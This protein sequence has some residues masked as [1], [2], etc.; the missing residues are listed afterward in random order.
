MEAIMRMTSSYLGGHFGGPLPARATVVTV[1]EIIVPAPVRL[2]QR[3]ARA[4]LVRDAAAFAA[5]VV[6]ATLF[7][8]LSGLEAVV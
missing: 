1:E 4:A 3:I 7:S 6:L 8:V 5:L 2:A